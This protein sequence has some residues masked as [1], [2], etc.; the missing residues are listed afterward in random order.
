MNTTRSIPASEAAARTAKAIK[1]ANVLRAAG[2]TAEMAQPAP[3]SFWL[4]T[5]QQACVRSALPS[6]RHPNGKTPSEA[7]WA[8]VLDMLPS[9]GRCAT[10]TAAA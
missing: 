7:T 5:A 1:M 10:T 4:L 9:S 8:L 3:P 2:I 6:R